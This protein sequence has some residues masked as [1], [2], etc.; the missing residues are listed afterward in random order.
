[1]QFF[2]CLAD[3]VV[4]FRLGSYKNGDLSVLEPTECVHLPD[5]MKRVALV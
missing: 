5:T 1:M 3:N 2:L 4:G